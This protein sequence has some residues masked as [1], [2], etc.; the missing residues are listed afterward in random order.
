MTQLPASLSHLPQ[1][2][3]QNCHIADA[4]QATNYTLCVYLMKMREYYRWEKGYG[5]GERLSSEAVG[6]WLRK[7]EALWEELEDQPFQPLTINGR[8]YPPFEAD[9]INEQLEAHGLLYSAG[10]GYGNSAH[11]FLGK[12][13][14]SEQQEDF[15]VLI[16]D[17]ELARDLTAPPA[18][19]QGRVIYIRR[20]SLRRMIW[21]KLEEWR[22]SRLDNAMG[23]ALG[24]YD[25]DHDF[26]QALHQMTA[27][28]T[29]TV[30]NHE[31]GEIM[32]GERLGD[33]WEEMLIQIPTHRTQLL[34]RLV[35]D[36]LADCL[37]TLPQLLH[38]DQPPSSLHFYIATLSNLRKHLFPGLVTAYQYWLESGDPEKL[39]SIIDRGRTHW[40]Q[41]AEQ[42]MS[43]FSAAGATADSKIAGLIEDNAL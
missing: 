42:V 16:A 1:I 3:Q 34:L 14:Q 21:E 8:D 29:R 31:L 2:V 6:E 40:Q 24:A 43:E 32:A 11:F 17:T 37:S 25:F 38:G 27:A 12:R 39:E 4:A 20:E 26:D 35:R 10:L 15:R 36:N 41:V 9:A 18:L 7:R 23:R 5:F 13:V 19:S 33:S 28:E 22:W 30:L